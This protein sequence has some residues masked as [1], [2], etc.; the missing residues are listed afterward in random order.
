MPVSVGYQSGSHYSTVQALDQ[1]LM[2][3][4]INLSFKD[5][6]L[7]ARME[8]L[9]EGQAPAV[10]LFGGPYYFAE[11][12]GYKKIID[13]T[14]MIATM[15]PGDPDPEDLKKF[16]RALRQAQRDID[17]RPDFIP[18]T[19][20]RN[21]PSASTP[22]MDSRRWDAGERLVFEPYTKEVY[23]GSFKW[24]PFHGIFPEGK[25]GSGQYERATL[26]LS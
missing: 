15:I 26:S 12:M 13:S 14:F 6:M 18:T 7:F 5:G 23:E 16:F 3:D 11:Q 17:L 1:Y 25:M 10:R 21:S 4:Q 19:T 24:I 20:R 8:K 2:P 22:R 9:V